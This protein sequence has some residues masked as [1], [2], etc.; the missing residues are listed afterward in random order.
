MNVTVAIKES[1]CRRDA[2]AGWSQTTTNTEKECTR[3]RTHTKTQALSQLTETKHDLEQPLAQVLVCKIYD[4]STSVEN[5]DANGS[6]ATQDPQDR[7][8]N[9]LPLGTGH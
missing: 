5:K 1:R 8:N 3:A 9:M 7:K 2:G 4:T 6:H